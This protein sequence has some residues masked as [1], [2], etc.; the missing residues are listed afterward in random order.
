M[1]DAKRQINSV[2]RTVGT[3]TRDGGEAHLATITQVYPTG[4]DD[5]WEAVTSAERIPR[6]FLPVTGDLVEGGRYQLEGNAGGTITSCD[7]PRQFEATWEYDGN[8][9]WITVR[10]TPEDADHTRF[11]LEHVAHVPTEFWDR[12]GPGATG[13]GWD[14]GLMGLALHVPA[15]EQPMDPAAAAALMASDEG[16]ELLRLSSE[17]WFDADVASGS[18]PDVA[19]GMADRTFAAYAGS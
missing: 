9:S 14:M 19:R 10:L 3:R 2:R 8:V 7:K 13:I 4:I 12:F 18:D 11:D 1:I 16:R 15:P 17:A 6:W 5:L